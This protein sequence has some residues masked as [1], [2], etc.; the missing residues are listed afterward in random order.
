MGAARIF[1]PVWYRSSVIARLL[2]E[3]VD[4]QMSYITGTNRLLP[5]R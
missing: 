5:G 3:T 4:K 1:G 2:A